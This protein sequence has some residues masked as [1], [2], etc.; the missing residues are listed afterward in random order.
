VIKR[1]INWGRGGRRCSSPRIN[2]TKGEGGSGL[3]QK[4]IREREEK[5]KGKEL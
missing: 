3:G 5:E 2:K 1:M 4:S